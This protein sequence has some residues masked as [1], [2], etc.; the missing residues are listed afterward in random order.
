[1]AAAL[2]IAAKDLK[3][4]IR[5]RSALIIGIVAPLSLAF[6]FNLVFGGATSG[7]GLGLE[8]GMVDDDASEISG[9]FVAV[10]E[11]A[12]EAGVLELEP[13]PDRE[14]AQISVESDEIDAYFVIPDGLG[15]SVMGGRSDVIEVVGSVNSPTS[16]QIAVS[17][18]ERFSSSLGA[19]QL[20]VATAADVEGVPVTGEYVAGLSQ[21]PATASQTFTIEDRSAET[22]QLDA[23][24][25][26]AAGMAVFF[27]FFTV[28]V[29]VTG[30]LDERR[31]GT[32]ARLIAA[33][34]PRAAVI[35]G[36]GLVAFLLGVISM[37]VLVVATSLLMGADWGAPLGVA[38][39]VAAGVLSAVGIMGIVAAF[40][41]TPEGAGN[42]GSIIAVILGMLGGTFFPIGAT[43]GLLSNLTYLTPHAWFLRGLG[44]L[45]SGAP[46]TNALPSAG[47]MMVFALVTGLA[48]WA[49]LRTR[50]IQ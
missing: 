44:D 39:L 27:L 33:P 17:F 19:G 23:S 30:L 12:E 14:Q 35:A 20:A 4:R 18:A 24:T 9:A 29:G 11:G 49:V 26:F 22:R 47:A 41:R 5:D 2:R 46:W 31:D 34:I 7:A 38:V 3:L 50:G 21:D 32:M 42:L 8:Y 36:K 13:Y 43:G 25:F 28:Q 1:V 37:T 16:T 6:I 40:A 45:A 15:Q 10:L 48:A